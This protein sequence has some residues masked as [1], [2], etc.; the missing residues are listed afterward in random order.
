MRRLVPGSRGHGFRVHTTRQPHHESLDAPAMTRL[1]L[2]VDAGNVPSVQS[3]RARGAYRRY[4][5]HPRSS[6]PALDDRSGPPPPTN[7]VGNT[8][9]QHPPCSRTPSPRGSTGDGVPGVGEYIMLQQ[10]R[11]ADPLA[12]RCN[13]DVLAPMRGHMRTARGASAG[14]ALRGLQREVEVGGRYVA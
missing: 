8:D 1:P 4:R 7:L 6:N 12:S 3:K 14:D 11:P 5:S 13:R 9:R 2:Y 10:S